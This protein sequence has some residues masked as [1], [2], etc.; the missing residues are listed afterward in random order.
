MSTQ[1]DA[2]V[3]ISENWHTKSTESA[4]TLLETSADGLSPEEV[5][6]RLDQYGPLLRCLFSLCLLLL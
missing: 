2:S 6:K 5:E 4:Y 3:L 1:A